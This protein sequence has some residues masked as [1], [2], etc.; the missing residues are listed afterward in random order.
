MRPSGG[1]MPGGGMGIGGIIIVIIIALVFGASNLARHF[2]TRK[3]STSR[4]ESPSTALSSSL[5]ESAS[6]WGATAAAAH[7]CKRPALSLSIRAGKA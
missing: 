7:K 3:A 2:L 4:C 6:R 1:G 5:A